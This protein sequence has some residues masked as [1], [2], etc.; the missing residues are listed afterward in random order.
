MLLVTG[1][2]G[3]IGRELVG[4]LDARGAEDPLPGTRSGCLGTGRTG[5]GGLGLAGH[6]GARVRRCRA[7]VPARA[8]YR[9][10]ARRVRRGRR[11]GGRR[12]AHRASLVQQRRR[13]ADSRDGPLAPRP[14]ADHP[15]LRHSGHVPAPRRLHDQRPG[16]GRHPARGATSWIR[17]DRVVSRRSTRRHRRRRRA[18]ADRGR[19]PGTRSTCSPAANCSPSPRWSPRSG[20]GDRARDRGAAG[21]HARGGRAVGGFPTAHRRRWPTR[22]W[23]GS[24]CC[25]PTRSP[26][27]A[28]PLPVC[29]AG[30]HTRSRTGVRATFFVCQRPPDRRAGAPTTVGG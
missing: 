8:R 6:A 28:T 13:R 25:V 22:S 9:H 11:P 16:M 12:A 21:G 14:R 5:R 29:S 24:R 7:V 20:P 30:R 18:R 10:R 17:S 1:A 19:P 2:T 23:R 4:Q 15:R 26:T 27:A 3:N